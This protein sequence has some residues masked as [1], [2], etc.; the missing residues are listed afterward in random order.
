VPI[1]VDIIDI[2]SRIYSALQT[3]DISF[4]QSIEFLP[5]DFENE[6]SIYNQIYSPGSFEV[7]LS[8]LD[9]IDQYVHDTVH[10]LFK[11]AICFDTD[12]FSNFLILLAFLM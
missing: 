2:I 6:L 11:R 1:D 3:I 4:Q 9:M 7:Q 10:N 8:E 5:D 12:V